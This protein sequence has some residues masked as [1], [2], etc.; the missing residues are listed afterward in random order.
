M[1]AAGLTLERL[2]AGYGG[3]KTRAYPDAVFKSA[4]RARVD[5]L[6]RAG[7]AEREMERM[8]GLGFKAI[9]AYDPRYP[10]MLGQI[11]DPPLALYVQGDPKWLGEPSIAIVGSRDATAYGRTVAGHLAARLA[12][13]GLTI[14]S[15]FARGIDREAHQG[16]LRASGTTVAVLGC[17]L[18]IDYPAGQWKL[19]EAISANGCLVSEFPL[20]T[21][22]AEYTFPRRN[23]IVSGLSLGVVVVEAGEKSGALI[24]ARLAAEQGRE[25][26][27]VPGSVF[28]PATR[29]THALLRDGAKLTEDAEDVLEEIS[30]HF[31]PAPRTTATAPD[32]GT[33]EARVL[34]AITAE[35][36]HIDALGR[37]L[38]MPMSALVPALSLLEVR[39]CVR[40][41]AGKM[42][43]LS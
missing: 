22:P 43:S 30:A 2:P 34:G 10:R 28:S 36:L 37:K 33:T 32:P 16:A 38:S 1:N 17:G 7:F 15:G 20:G 21:S 5:E 11:S 18:D 39:G 14:V 29:G 26:F 8:N 3:G 25:V 35:P 24:T 40:Q 27:A 4:E 6:E 41:H 23:R 31:T 42:F 9:T 19:R 13:R 12:A